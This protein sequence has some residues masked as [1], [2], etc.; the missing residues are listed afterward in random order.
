MPRDWRPPP[1]DENEEGKKEEEDNTNKD[2]DDDGRSQSASNQDR[3]STRRD[4]VGIGDHPKRESAEE[5]EAG[6]DMDDEDGHY[7]DDGDNEETSSNAGVHEKNGLA[8]PVEYGFYQGPQAGPSYDQAYYPSLLAPAS[9]S[10]VGPQFREPARITSLPRG[11]G[12]RIYGSY[13]PQSS[14]HYEPID[15]C[16]ESKPS[17]VAPLKL[18][19]TNN[20][21]SLLCTQQ[22]F[23]P[24]RQGNE[25][26]L[27][28]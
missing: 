9:S 18:L 14:L 24:R 16:T 12:P 1:E 21:S 17:E 4:L 23:L 2:E 3:T 8:V 22:K 27:V 5:E 28:R 11:E 20:S 6:T 25:H 26:F 10:F 19:A 13:G 7:D 15:P